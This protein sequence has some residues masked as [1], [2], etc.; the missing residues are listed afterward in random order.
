MSRVD[1]HVP[2]ILVGVGGG[3]GGIWILDMS[4]Q[5]RMVLNQVGG[6]ANVNSRNLKEQF[7]KNI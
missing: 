5:R 1:L 7:E 3:R 4:Q 6:S 2:R